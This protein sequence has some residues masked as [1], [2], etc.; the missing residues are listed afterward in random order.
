MNLI[1]KYY[2][3]ISIYLI[4]WLYYNVPCKDAWYY[5]NKIVKGNNK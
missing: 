3:I 2:I 4:E 1:I 5:A